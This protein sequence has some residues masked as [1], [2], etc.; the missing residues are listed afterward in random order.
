MYLVT[1]IQNK[2]HSRKVDTSENIHTKERNKK[3]R[4]NSL[5]LEFCFRVFPSVCRL[6][7]ISS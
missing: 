6:F 4:L 1:R 3:N 2:L 7:A 5:C